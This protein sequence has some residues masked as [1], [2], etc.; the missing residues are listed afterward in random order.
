MI[1]ATAS[2][3]ETMKEMSGSFDLPSGVGTQMTMASASFSAPTSRVAPSL[4]LRTSGPSTAVGTSS[5]ND[6]PE[7]TPATRRGSRSRPMA[8]APDWAKATASGRPT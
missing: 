5:M 2:A 8:V 6:S 3:A 7:A 1:E 4:P